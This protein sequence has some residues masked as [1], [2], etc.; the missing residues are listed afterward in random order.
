[1][2]MVVTALSHIMK[3]E[4]YDRAQGTLCRIVLAMIACHAS[5]LAQ[6]LEVKRGMGERPLL[7]GGHRDRPR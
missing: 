2:S 5:A 7:R 6:E 4:A 3:G 1:M